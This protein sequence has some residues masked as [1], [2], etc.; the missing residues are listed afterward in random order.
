MIRPKIP[1]FLLAA[2]AAALLLLIPWIQPTVAQDT[3]TVEPTPTSTPRPMPPPFTTV[4]QDGIT[5]DFFFERIPQG[6]LGLAR[7]TGDISEARAILVNNEFDFFF[8]PDENAWF[9][10]IV[11]NMDLRPRDY[12]LSLIA[13]TSGGENVAFQAT[14]EV[15]NAGFIRQDFIIPPERAYLIDPEIERNEFARL[16]SIFAQI[17][18]EKL[19]TES[20]FELPIQDELTSPFGVYRTLNET[21]QTRHTGW[22]LRATVGTPIVAMG[23][24]RV[25]FAGQMDIRGN[26]VIIDHGHGLFSGYSH[27]SQVHVTTGQSIAPGQIIGVTGNTGRSNGPHLHWEV[28]VNGEWVDSLDVLNLWLP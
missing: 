25:A 11:V 8:V 6:S 18:D 2:C 7:L 13:R 15:E 14:I 27:L 1:L 16:D 5:L 28:A 17:T 10:F 24:G 9:A 22:D 21:V 19:W 20:S 26:H 12:A 3:A 4:G 23:A